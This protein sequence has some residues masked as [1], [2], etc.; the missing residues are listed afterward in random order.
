MLAVAAS[1]RIQEILQERDW[2]WG[3]MYSSN[4]G[5]AILFH[6]FLIE[7]CE[8]D[9]FSDVARLININILM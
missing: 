6:A 3:L 1:P 9:A 4:I 5:K 2:S 7:T 8:A